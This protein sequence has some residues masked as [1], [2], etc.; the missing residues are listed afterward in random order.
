MPHAT[1]MPQISARSASRPCR[2]TF[3]VQMPGHLILL[4]T[5]LDGICRAT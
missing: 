2:H 1:H 3:D 5:M 4:A